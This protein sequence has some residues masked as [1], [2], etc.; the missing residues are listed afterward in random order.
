M[1]FIDCEFVDNQ[2]IIELSV[3]NLQGREVYH[4]FFKPAGISK[5]PT[6]MAIHHITPADV[7]NAPSFASSLPE[8][9]RL[10]DRSRYIIGFATGG[11]IAH[12]TNMGV[13]GLGDKH[14]IDV[15]QM[16][17][18]YYGRQAGM[19][20]YSLPGLGRCAEDLGISFG[21]RGAHS[22]SEDTLVT[23]RCFEALTDCIEGK[24]YADRSEEGFLKAMESYMEEFA[25]EKENYERQR[26][27]GWMIVTALP[28]GLY[29]VQFKRAE[30]E[31]SPELALKVK[32]NDMAKAESD[33]HVQLQKRQTPNRRGVYRLTKSDLRKLSLYTNTFGNTEE[34]DLSRKLLKLQKQWP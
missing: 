26:A 19:D 12:L 29:R 1:L 21:D 17:W 8:I 28:D 20:Y 2:E 33:L 3:W 16:Y 14:I 32:V 18:L 15:K 6:S 9:Q 13:R 23:L 27:I 7:K 24:P 25:R 5:W 11:D 4:K 30:P 34:H 22:A 10:F 31:E